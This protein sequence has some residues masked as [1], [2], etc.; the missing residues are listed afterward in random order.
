ML[1]VGNE[2]KDVLGAKAAG[3]TA[4]LIWRSDSPVPAWGQDFTVA[5]LEQLL[6][7][8]IEGDHTGV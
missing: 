8:V 4:A 5:S 6:P 7:A 3:M 2:Q 1:F